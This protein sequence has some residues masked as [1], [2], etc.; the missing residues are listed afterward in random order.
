MST[1][2]APPQNKWSDKIFI[3]QLNTGKCQTLQTLKN[4]FWSC[5]FD[6]KVRGNTRKKKNRNDVLRHFAK[7]NYKYQNC[8]A[9]RHTKKM[10][11]SIFFTHT[12]TVPFKKKTKSREV[13]TNGPQK[14][15]QISKCCSYRYRLLLFSHCALNT[16]C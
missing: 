16:C 6:W 7:Y 10:T 8:L 5:Q 11:H 1:P 14:N 2:A 9:A 13:N 3:A 15:P 12:N 4:V